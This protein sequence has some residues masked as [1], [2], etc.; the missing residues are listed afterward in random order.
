MDFLTSAPIV[1]I[2]FL[3]VL[4]IVVDALTPKSER[5]TF[6]FAGFSMLAAMLMAAFTM[7]N[8]GTAFNGMITT[9]GVATFFDILFCMGGLLTLFAARPYILRENVEHDE[10]Y[11]LILYAVAGM[12]VI[13][14]AH[15][16]LITF[17]GIEIMSVSFYVLAGY[18]RS[19]TKSVESALKYFLLGA[20]A[21]G[22]LVFG[23]S[24]LYGSTGTLDYTVMANNIQSGMINFP[25]LLSVGTGLLIVGL[26][27]KMAAFPFHQWVPDVYEGAPT[28]VTG[29]MSTAGKAAS[30]SALMPIAYAII[31]ESGHQVAGLLAIIAAGTMLVGNISAVV[32]QN[33]KRMLAYSSVAHAGYI[34]MGFVANNEKGMTGIVYYVTAYL[35]MQLGA[36]VLVSLIERN[37]DKQLEL[38]DYAGLSKKHPVIAALMAFFMFSLA[39]IPPMAGFF[40]KYYLFIAA[41]E[42]GYTWLTIVAVISSMISV[43][44]YIGLVVQMYFKDAEG[45]GIDAHQPGLAGLTLTVATFF[46]IALGI[47]PST[48]EQIARSFFK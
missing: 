47:M 2:S 11:T 28:V 14:H 7:P 9:G 27:F 45:E 24:F 15:N 35:F 10:F 4:C 17:I 5:I 32:Q 33:I 34:L 6:Y 13:A 16:L 37:I 40:G 48:V 18:F 1:L 43:Y 19:N 8:T 23:M 42:S 38:R 39:G 25:M 41:I 46:V 3:S 26:S 30:V 31:G 22:F 44:F 29:F 12:M 36:F 21:T 20:F